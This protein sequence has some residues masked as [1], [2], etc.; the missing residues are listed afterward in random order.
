M[1]VINVNAFQKGINKSDFLTSYTD[2]YLKQSL[3]NLGQRVSTKGDGITSDSFKVSDL[4]VDFLD[5]FA[6]PGRFAK[7]TYSTKE[8][9]VDGEIVTLYQNGTISSLKSTHSGSFITINNVDNVFDNLRKDQYNLDFVLDNG[10]IINDTDFW[11][12]NSARLIKT[13]DSYIYK[14]VAHKNS[15][16]EGY[17]K[18]YICEEISTNGEFLAGFRVI[19]LN[20]FDCKINGIT[21]EEEIGLLYLEK[22][23]RYNPTIE[24]SYP[25]HLT[26]YKISN[27]SI[28]PGFSYTLNSLIET[29]FNSNSVWPSNTKPSEII[30][31]INTPEAFAGACVKVAT[32]GIGF[33]NGVNQYFSVI[34]STNLTQTYSKDYSNKEFLENKLEYFTADLTELFPTIYKII[35]DIVYFSEDNIKLK[36]QIVSNLVVQLHKDILDQ[37]NYDGELKEETYIYMPLDYE[38]A[39]TVNDNDH[40]IIYNSTKNVNVQFLPSVNADPIFKVDYLYKINNTQEHNDQIVIAD[41]YE[42]KIALY[43][44]SIDYIVDSIINNITWASSFILPYINSDGFWVVN[45]INTN[46]YAIGKNA[47]QPNIIMMNSISPSKSE[48]STYMYIHAIEKE[49]ISSWPHELKGFKM[50][51][52]D[53]DNNVA[54][55]NT[56]TLSAWLPSDDYINSI[57]NTNEFSLIKNSLIVNMCSSYME[58]DPPIISY[59]NISYYDNIQILNQVHPINND[60]TY[61]ATHGLVNRNDGSLNSIYTYEYELNPQSLVYKLGNK[62][63]ISSFWTCQ[64]DASTNSYSMDYLKQPNSNVALDFAYLGNL[65]HYIKYYLNTQFEPDNYEHT[66][67]VFDNTTKTLK[68]NTKNDSKNAWPNMR[69]LNQTYFTTD[70]GKIDPSMSFGSTEA[71][72]EDDPTKE[73]YTN[74]LNLQIGFNDRVL[75]NADGEITYVGQSARRFF[76]INSYELNEY[77]VTTYYDIQY[78]SLNLPREFY[79]TS[80]GNVHEFSISTTRPSGTNWDKVT[81][82]R[83][84]PESNE[85]EDITVYSS[86]S[87]SDSSIVSTYFG[88]TQKIGR[89]GVSYNKGVLPKLIRYSEY[90][91]EYL[92]NSYYDANTNTYTYQYPQLDLKEVLI[93]NNNVINRTNLVAFERHPYSDGISRNY[94][95]TAYL[96]TAYDSVDKST[97]HLGTGSKNIN[98][99]TSTMLKAED[100]DKFN[101]VSR[102]SIDINN[103]DINGDTE[104]SKQVTADKSIWKKD[105]IKNS[106]ISAFSTILYPISEVTNQDIN[107]TIGDQNNEWLDKP[108][109]EMSLLSTV[110]WK[111]AGH[112]TSRYYKPTSNEDEI[113]R[114][115]SYLNITQLLKDND[116]LIDGKTYINCDSQLISTRTINDT[117]NMNAVL[118]AYLGG[119]YDDQ[120][121]WAYK[122]MSD[123][124]K[125]YVYYTNELLL[126]ENNNPLV[127]YYLDDRGNHINATYIDERGNIA[128][129]VD[130]DGN[131]VPT[132][133]FKMHQVPHIDMTKI[134]SQLTSYYLELS[135]EIDN[136]EN[137]L[138]QYI[139]NK[140][141]TTYINSVYVGNSIAVTY[142]DLMSYSASV[143]IPEPRMVYTYEYTTSYEETWH[144]HGCSECS[145]GSCKMIKWCKFSYVVG[146]HKTSY[147]FTFDKDTIDKHVY[148][149]N[150]VRYLRNSD[151]T[152][153]PYKKTSYYP[154]QKFYYIDTAYMKDDKT[155]FFEGS[156]YTWK[157]KNDFSN[158]YAYIP[159][160][161]NILCAYTSDWIELNIPN[162]EKERYTYI[163][164]GDN[165]GA[166]S[167]LNPTT[168]NQEYVTE[169]RVV[170]KYGT[171][172]V[173]NYYNN[174][175]YFNSMDDLKKK[176]G[177]EDN[178]YSDWDTNDVWYWNKE[179]EPD[180]KAPNNLYT[181]YSDVKTTYMIEV[182]DSNDTYFP[183]SYTTEV[184]LSKFTYLSPELGYKTFDLSYRYVNIRELITPHS[185][186]YFQN[187]IISFD[188]VEGSENLGVFGH[189][190]Q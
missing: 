158:T 46:I 74:D 83:V 111:R 33:D 182:V 142:I 109:H 181:Y 113:V 103:V 20:E 88:L 47:G 105:K 101:P 137:L 161:H 87:K 100:I 162:N 168:G 29:I 135:T 78:N 138:S 179:Q 115:T 75:R 15:G 79:T 70:L 45:G 24:K 177:T 28:A 64:Y 155:Y 36:K 98:V 165:G 66:W 58:L 176:Y 102:F 146:N 94:I 38:F 82:K 141:G 73:L 151:G 53:S 3:A 112:N 4:F 95:Y 110:T 175:V 37:E 13:R 91:L 188:Q 5:D 30:R 54:E 63:V 184:Y 170:Y 6:A 44:F 89:E 157:I 185:R 71:T 164:E 121:G 56:I 51:Y 190:I 84:N 35:D 133:Y 132:T 159:T 76:T 122:N 156:T 186:P 55:A 9:K 32:I 85:V 96:G 104:F 57:R 123:E 97:I 23:D 131:F 169:E 18:E 12:R 49:L 160:G 31:T 116:I 145:E 21:N 25:Y 16:E 93:R 129:Y 90:P 11:E 178:N 39:Y 19:Y 172:V 143:D 77:E 65:E 149:Y 81:T 72:F 8:N 140:E 80:D 130:K 152:L 127:E 147:G 128:Y 86:P 41:S 154:S 124:M 150:H 59:T 119:E 118:Q 144:C 92:P 166:I 180:Q 153:T 189:R 60:Q 171:P 7:F 136:S 139:Q 107:A 43:G 125:S 52:L 108:L 148:S 106:Y 69:N 134:G 174:V 40:S 99:G 120:N 67:V 173:M 68:N 34:D 61:W 27:A 117:H 167:Y 1:S 2:V 62:G 126:D 114:K 26:L 42:D 10:S 50:N 22:N 14:L 187:S 17:T 163:N 183:F 48:N